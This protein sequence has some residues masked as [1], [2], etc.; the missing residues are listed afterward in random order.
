MAE[1]PGYNPPRRRNLK[2]RGG[3]RKHD[4]A[5][6]NPTVPS[7]RKK[8]DR[9]GPPTYVA[10]VHRPLPESG[11]TRSRACGEEAGKVHG[12]EAKGMVHPGAKEGGS[13][14]HS[15]FAGSSAEWQNG[16]GRGHEGRK[17]KKGEKGGRSGNVS[18]PSNHKGWRCTNLKTLAGVDGLSPELTVC[19]RSLGRLRRSSA[20]H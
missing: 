11:H 16:H 18:R 15:P 8:V 17:W 20:S 7:A 14:F 6:R 3:S 2:S 12:I 1:L 19:N 9:G 4:L 13:C 10:V 5:S